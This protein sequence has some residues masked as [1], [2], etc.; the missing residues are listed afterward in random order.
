MASRGRVYDDTE[1]VYAADQRMCKVA[2]LIVAPG[3]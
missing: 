3:G 1:E 2:E